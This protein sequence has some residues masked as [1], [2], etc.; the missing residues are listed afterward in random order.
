MWNQNTENHGMLQFVLNTG[1]G[2]SRHL[3]ENLHIF[4]VFSWVVL[5]LFPIQKNTGAKRKE[6]KGPNEP[7]LPCNVRLCK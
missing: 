2:L 4:M 7:Y 1:F 5:Y 3:P 6:V